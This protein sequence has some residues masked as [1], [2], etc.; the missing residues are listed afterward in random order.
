MAEKAIDPDQIGRI[1]LRIKNMGPGSAKKRADLVDGIW[2]AAEI[3]L[4]AA[5]ELVPIETGALYR[6]GRVRVDST[7][8]KITGY[9]LFGG[10][11]FGIDYAGY[12]HEDMSKAHGAEYNTKY[13]GDI[14]SGKKTAKRPQER[15]KFLEI[16]ARTNMK[17]MRG[18]LDLF[19]GKVSI[20]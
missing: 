16:A 11:N 9:V 5:L 20:Q 1:L 12:V 15:A 10:V 3:C 2:A 6:S 18:A 7:G 19:I 14:A 13:A 4:K 8:L 17:Q